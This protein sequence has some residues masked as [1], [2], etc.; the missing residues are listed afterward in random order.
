[1]I[2]KSRKINDKNNDKTRTLFLIRNNIFKHWDQLAFSRMFFS[3]RR[4]LFGDRA[5]FYP[6]VEQERLLLLADTNLGPL[7]QSTGRL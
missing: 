4:T 2:F 7:R 5:S 6:Q 3:Q 1:M